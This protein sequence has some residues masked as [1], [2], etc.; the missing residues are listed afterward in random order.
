MADPNNTISE[1]EQQSHNPNNDIPT[2]GQNQEAEQQSHNPNNDIP[3]QGQDQG[4]GQ[5]SHAPDDDTTTQGQNQEAEQQSNDPNDSTPTQS[6]NQEVEQQSHDT[7][8]GTPSAAVQEE[9]GLG[10]TPRRPVEH[11]EAPSGALYAVRDGYTP[12]NREEVDKE[13][14]RAGTALHFHQCKSLL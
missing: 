13:I 8:D 7:S 6:Q 5:Q 3:T 4:L 2:Q 9:E 14:A 10:D 1:A 12:R 11:I